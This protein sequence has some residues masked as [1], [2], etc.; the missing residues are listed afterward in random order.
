[1]K[2]RGEKASEQVNSK[3]NHCHFVPSLSRYFW[4]KTLFKLYSAASPSLEL[5]KKNNSCL[6]SLS[7]KAHLRTLVTAQP[8]FTF[9]AGSPLNFITSFHLCNLCTVDLIL[10]TA[11]STLCNN[12]MSM[13]TGTAC[14]LLYFV[15][16]ALWSG[17]R[18]GCSTVLLSDGYCT[19]HGQITASC[20]YSKP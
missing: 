10:N 4:A 13:L 1:M 9:C 14:T 12:L 2:G 15:F 7:G 8:N 16:R 3:K 17:H 20:F 5:Y 19:H 18:K 6:P 11:C